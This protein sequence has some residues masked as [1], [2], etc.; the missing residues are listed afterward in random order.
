MAIPFELRPEGADKNAYTP[1]FPLEDKFI[2]T[3]R[4]LSFIVANQGTDFKG[5]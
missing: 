4:T 3:S 2:H 5:T 1:F